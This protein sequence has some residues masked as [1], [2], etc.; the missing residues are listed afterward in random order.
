MVTTFRTCL[1]SEKALKLAA[2]KRLLAMILILTGISFGS[3]DRNRNH[4]GWDYFPDMYYSN[5]YESYTP[6]PNFDD[7]STLRMPVEGTISREQIPYPFIKT[8]EDMALAGEL[9]ENPVEITAENLQRGK[10]TYIRYCNLCHGTKGEGDGFLFTS[11]KYLLPPAS[12]T[13]ERAMNRSEGELFH[14]ITVGFGVMGAHGSQISESDRW[15]IVHYIREE[16]QKEFVA[17][18][19]QN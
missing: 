17:D 8:D 12:L 6:N 18:D 7:G 14:S 19:A 3:C 1:N 15:K 9:L 4:P 13:A 5:A 16:L 10:E 11:G 2:G